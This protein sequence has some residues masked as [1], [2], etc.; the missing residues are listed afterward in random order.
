MA[1]VAAGGAACPITDVQAALHGPV[2]LADADGKVVV[3]LAVVVDFIVEAEL[4]VVEAMDVVEEGMTTPD[5][6]T[7]H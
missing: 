3:E 7:A 4:A 6:H 5:A 1:P 2:E